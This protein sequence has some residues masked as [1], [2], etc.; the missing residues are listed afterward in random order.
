MYPCFCCQN[1]MFQLFLCCRDGKRDDIAHLHLQLI[2]QLCRLWHVWCCSINISQNVCHHISYLS[3]DYVLS[4]RWEITANDIFLFAVHFWM[5]SRCGNSIQPQIWTFPVCL[6]ENV[7]FILSS[8]LHTFSPN[9]TLMSHFVKTF[10][11]SF[12]YPSFK[13]REDNKSNM[14]Q[15]FWNL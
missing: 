2:P 14:A 5:Q 10:L 7:K 6:W 11:S 1:S 4:Q 9:P 12:L 13:Q 3:W 8:T 15:N